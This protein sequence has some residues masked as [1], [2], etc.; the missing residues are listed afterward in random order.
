MSKNKVLAF[1]STYLDDM[2]SL[3]LMLA[4][5][6]NFLLIYSFKTTKTT[7]AEMTFSDLTSTIEFDS[8]FI[9]LIV[10]VLAG[11]VTVLAL[12]VAVSMC[13]TFGPLAVKRAWAQ[14]QL[15]LGK[16]TA[17][18]EI[19]PAGTVA[20]LLRLGPEAN[21]IFEGT[22]TCGARV[23]YNIYSTWY[24]LTDMA[25]L[26]HMIYFIFAVC[27]NL[28]SPF[29]LCLHLFDLVYRSETLKNVLR[30]VT[31]NGQQLLMTAMLCLIIIYVYAIIGFALLRNNYFNDDFSDE[32]MCDKLL[33]CL[34]VTVREGLINGG[35][36]GDYLQPR[37]VS[38][39]GPYLGRFF[40]DL[41]FFVL[42]III[43]LNVIFGIIIDTFAAMRE[44]TDSKANDM[45]TVC[46]ICGN[47]RPTMDRN[48]SGFDNH[49]E[50]E[51]NMWKYAFYIV[52]LLQKDPTEYTGLETFVFKMIEEEDMNFYPLHKAMCLDND[53]EEED[54]F[55][56]EVSQKFSGLSNDMA[57]LKKTVV[58]I[59]SESITNQ[60]N[61]VDL[62]K[63]ALRMLD[64]IYE[65]QQKNAKV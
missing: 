56:V 61:L 3:Q 50:K 63:Q 7:T 54:P 35:G 11:L 53:D 23:V 12:L 38:D 1:L 17:D 10:R 27:G 44:V 40:F 32:R 13:K 24:Y 19:P 64:S 45:K 51:H 16:P 2:K 4:L 29:F 57:M 62:N 48:G 6:I 18:E 25:I 34:M 21:G 36:M 15:E 47:D 65:M 8:E 5:A 20:H 37:A 31:F 14:R 28:V 52:Y 33:D 22:T 55:Q 46:F 39:I 30:A 42:I 41:S 9:Q 58:E 43:L 49:I 60:S 59:K 26:V